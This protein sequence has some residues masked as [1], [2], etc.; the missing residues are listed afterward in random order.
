MIKTLK[1]TTLSNTLYILLLL[2]LILPYQYIFSSVAYI[3]LVM[4]DTQDTQTFNPSCT[5]SD[6]K[7][8]RKSFPNLVVSTDLTEVPITFLEILMF[9]L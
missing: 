2:L 4:D 7:P 1:K 3:L 5:D 8:G 9:S 6:S